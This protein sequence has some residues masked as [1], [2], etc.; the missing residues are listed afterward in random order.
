[1]ELYHYE[2]EMEHISTPVSIS[3]YP[4]E[5]GCTN[6]NLLPA[7]LEYISNNRVPIFPLVPGKK[8]P[9]R[10]SHGHQDATTKRER[11]Q[12]WWSKYPDANIG[13]R[14]GRASGLVVLD[15]DSL[16]ALENLRR[17][18]DLPDTLT[19]T[20]PSG[21]AHLYFHA[22]SVPLDTDENVLEELIGPGLD[23]RADDGMVVLP[24]SRTSE[25]AY[26][27]AEP[28]PLA[29]LPEELVQAL[30]EDC[31]ASDNSIAPRSNR[32]IPYVSDG[33]PI[34]EGARNVTLTS[35][36]GR[37]HDGTRN[38][39][40]LVQ[41][42]LAVPTEKPVPSREA[43]K[44]AASI[45]SKE[46][47]RPGRGGDHGDGNSEVA[48]ILDRAG[49]YWYADLLPGGG[50][51]KARDVYRATMESAAAHGR[52]RT[53][54][55]DGVERRA[56]E[57][58]DS[59]RQIAQR[60]ATSR[61]SVRRNTER[62]TVHRAML[63]SHARD[64]TDGSTWL[65]LEPATNRD[66]PTHPAG[67]VAAL[68]VDGGCHSSS[69]SE[70][71]PRPDRLETPYFRAG[72]Y[73]GTPEPGLC[74][75]W[76]R[77]VLSPSRSLHLALVT[78]ESGITAACIYSRLLSLVSSRLEAGC[79]ASLVSTAGVPRRSARNATAPPVSAG[80]AATIPNRAG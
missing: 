48:E 52:V 74:M 69:R 49:A 38:R 31:G 14:T 73:I 24:P 16:E 62:L 57:F 80:F 47:C 61:E 29:E 4:S 30:V 8:V 43:E 54:T 46:P 19:A 58:T 63:R 3:A 78:P 56:V 41:A 11:V 37:L 39:E 15:A 35:C 22:P 33:E 72:G 7:A 79:M 32:A 51:S 55:V 75:L 2:P 64:D 36:A 50:K 40:E 53:V 59:Y 44:I 5:A 9:F 60:A 6:P 21:M 20:T 26:T 68:E 12:E 28:L 42:L 1:M 23:V 10:G 70:E 25:G 45:F 65:I 34:P 76:K 66:T 67:E 27:V 13:G 77:S 17:E 18:F 71:A